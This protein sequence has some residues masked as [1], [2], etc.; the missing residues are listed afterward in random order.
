ME[1]YGPGTLVHRRTFG[2]AIDAT[3]HQADIEQAL[4]LNGWTLE[5][6]TT[7]RQSTDRESPTTARPERRSSLRLVPN[8]E[9]PSS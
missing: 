4:V 9:D 1:V 7:E 6:L 5:Q 8:L 3:L 2:E